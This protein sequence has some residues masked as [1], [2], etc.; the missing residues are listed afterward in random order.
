[1]DGR[2]FIPGSSREYLS[3]PPCRDRFRGPN[4]LLPNGHGGYFPWGKVA[5][6]LSW[7]LTSI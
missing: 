5:G 2:G 6:A 1:M 3:W 7:P 4:S